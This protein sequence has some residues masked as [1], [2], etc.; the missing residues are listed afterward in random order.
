MNKPIVFDV[1]GTLID[2]DD[3][4]RKAVIEL[5][6]LLSKHY[7][8]FVWSGGGIEYARMWIQRLKLEKYIS[9]IVPKLKRPIKPYMTFDDEEITL[10]KF[11]VRV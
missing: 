1:D 7:D 6:K 3:K 5:L 8:I 4:P 11:N 2:F 10:G 9:S